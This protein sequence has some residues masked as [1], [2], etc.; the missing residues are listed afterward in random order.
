M[1]QDR[2]NKLRK[3]I[4]DVDNQLLNL[5]RKRLFLTK[6]I[7]DIKKENQINIIDMSREKELFQA[8]KQKCQEL[9]LDP[10]IIANI[11]HQILKASYKSQ[12]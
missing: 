5:I 6:E 1:I 2:I 12:E 4:D 7:G 3:E 11:W 10:L 8:L 9:K